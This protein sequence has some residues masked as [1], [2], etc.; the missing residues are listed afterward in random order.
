MKRKITFIIFL[1]NFSINFT[2]A[3]IQIPDLLIIENDT[4]YLQSFPLEDLKLKIRPFKYGDF[5]S[6]STAC[7]RG[8]RAI[9]KIIDKKLYLMEIIKVDS[10]KESLNLV[11]YFIANK[12]SF[13]TINGLIFAD[14]FSANLEKYSNC[15]KTFV[16]KSLK[17]RK[18]EILFSFKS[19]ILTENNYN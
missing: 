18:S 17:P 10:T 8:Y 12:Y 3:T 5:Y 13:M 16:F 6:P 19:G 4:L 1:L 14:W 2:N 9:W 7:W 15:G 11:N